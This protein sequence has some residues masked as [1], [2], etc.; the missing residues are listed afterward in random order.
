M[1]KI[2]IVLYCSFQ[3]LIAHSPIYAAGGEPKPRVYAV[4]V[5]ISDYLN[6]GID[7]LSFAHRDAEQF[8]DYL[9][10]PAGGSVPAEQIILLQNEKATFSAIYDALDWLVDTCHENDLVYFYFSGH[11]DM[12]NST[13]YKLGFLLSYNTPRTNYI[14]NAVRI[15][16]LNNYANTLSVKIKAKVILI[17]DACHSG[18]LAGN[19]FKGNLLVGEQLKTIQNNEIRITSCAPDQLSVED[20]KW[21]GGRGVFSYYL[22]NGLSGQADAKKDGAISVKELSD[23]LTG[24]LQTDLVLKERN[25][26]QTPII[27]GKNDFQLGSVVPNNIVQTNLSGTAPDAVALPPLPKSQMA[28]FF[29]L[30]N[31]SAFEKLC[32]FDELH[33]QPREKIAEVFLDQISAALNTF[34]NSVIT[35]FTSDLEEMA[36]LPSLIASNADARRRFEKK[37]V[38]LFISRGQTIINQYLSGDDAELERRRYYNAFTNDYTVYAKMFDLARKLIE[39]QSPLSKILAIKYHYFNAVSYRL[40]IFTEGKSDSLLKEAL[41]EQQIALSLEENAA[42]IYNDLGVIYQMS[43]EGLLAEQHFL[44]AIDI[45]PRWI[46]PITNLVNVYHLMG[47]YEKALQMSAKADSIQPNYYGNLVKTGMVYERKQNYLFAEECFRKSI[48]LNSRHYLPFEHLGNILLNTNQYVLAD[49]FYFEAE[50]RKRGFNG[51]FTSKID[52]EIDV[53]SPRFY[54]PAVCSFPDKIND[55][56]L[57]TLFVKAKQSKMNDPAEF[58]RLMKK[59]ISIDPRNPLAFHYLGKFMWEQQRRAEADIMLNL[60]ITNYLDTT[61]FAAYV[62]RYEKLMTRKD[63]CILSDFVKS[64]YEPLEDY[65]ILADVCEQW[66]HVSEAEDLYRRVM[67]LEPQYAGGY[68]KLWTLYEK[69]KRYR[70]AESV[71]QLYRPLF[72]DGLSQMNAFYRRM[73]K[74]LPESGEWFYSAGNFHYFESTLHPEAYTNDVFNNYIDADATGGERDV[75]GGYEEIERGEN[76]HFYLFLPG[77]NEMTVSGEKVKK[78]RRRA[79]LYFQQAVKF[80]TERETLADIEAKIGDMYAALHSPADAATHYQ[81]SSSLQGSNASTRLKLIDNWHAV[82]C[83]RDAQKQLD[84]L[85]DRAEINF[86]KMLLLA[87]FRIHSGALDQADTVL[88]FAKTIYPYPVPELYQLNGRRY[89]LSKRYAE[90]LPWYENYIQ[91]FS[92]DPETYYSMAKINFLTGKKEQGYTYLEKSIRAGFNCYWVLLRDKVWDEER[93]T[94]KWKLLTRDIHHKRFTMVPPPTNE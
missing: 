50:L 18:N 71:L 14:N 21:G 17:T 40:K 65:F 43:G 78:P 76:E 26:I 48:A 55:N 45:A 7:K 87:R 33:R 62:S 86:P 66:N 44:K 37:M 91:T 82:F 70:D 13:I 16:D 22:L 28:K 11:G 52:P 56:D 73:V 81:R 47:N 2:F 46:I 72:K 80:L 4:V 1:K 32:N 75:L 19:D 29:E 23:Y 38:E 94:E 35:V 60:A 36:S 42:Y 49:S 15:E 58:E 54:I 25:H 93:N 39:P 68:V 92:V 27:K 6:V 31:G 20:A 79:I 51:Y 67:A 9:K 88:R 34:D 77:T 69:Q 30:M 83:Y 74:A 3:F 10:S 89:M 90:A 61:R 12:E 41:K 84:T 24:A 53:A 64:H 5:G 63:S 57:I 8:A 85:W 59:L